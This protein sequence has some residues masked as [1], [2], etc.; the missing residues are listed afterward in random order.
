MINLNEEIRGKKKVR[1]WGGK[2]KY[3]HC[4]KEKK[5]NGRNMFH[6]KKCREKG[7][8]RGTVFKEKIYMKK[9]EKILIRG[10]SLF[11]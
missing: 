3:F 5:S 2:F 9:K 4:E 7:K 6:E 11:V 8:K 1:K 10:K